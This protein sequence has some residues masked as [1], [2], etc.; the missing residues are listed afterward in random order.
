MVGKQHAKVFSSL[1]PTK[2][3]HQ[4]T[5]EESSKPKTAFISH[6]GLFQYSRMPSGLTNAPARLMGKVF[7]GRDWDF[8]FMYLDDIP[9]TDN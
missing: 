1:D 4:V 2:G 7:G 3:Y 9:I 6:L 5:M 8:V